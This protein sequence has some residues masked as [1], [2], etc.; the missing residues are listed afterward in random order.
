MS[1]AEELWQALELREGDQVMEATLIAKIVH[2][3]DEAEAPPPSISISATDG[4]DWIQQAG[5]I[6]SALDL[7]KSGGFRK[8]ESD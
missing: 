8:R 3:G 2:F 6:H 7:L 4:L 1:E 5:L